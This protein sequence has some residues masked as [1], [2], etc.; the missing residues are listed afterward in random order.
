MAAAWKVLLV[1]CLVHVTLR[2]AVGLM[3]LL[4]ATSTSVEGC[5]LLLF[6]VQLTLNHLSYMAAVSHKCDKVQA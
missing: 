4:R 2:T 1:F 3:V 5:L 6:W